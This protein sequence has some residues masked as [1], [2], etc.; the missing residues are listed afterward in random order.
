MRGILFGLL[1]QLVVAVGFIWVAGLARDTNSIL[2]A[3]LMV[4]IAGVVAFLIVLF[5]ALF[6]DT[7]FSTFSRSDLLQLGF[8]SLLIL[9]VGESVYLL[10]LSAS[11][12]TTMGYTALAFPAIC[13]ALDVVTRRI[14]F[15][16]LTIRDY[17]GFLFLVIGFALIS[18]RR[19]A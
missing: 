17:A 3:N 14:P 16:S 19:H 13:L 12:A 11:N 18:S 4:C 8:A 15:S 9:V 1:Y 2:K 10:G 6:R 7:E 5:F